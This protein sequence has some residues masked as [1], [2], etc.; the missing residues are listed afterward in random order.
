MLGENIRTCNSRE[1]FLLS[2]AEF[3]SRAQKYVCSRGTY[4]TIFPFL[5]P[6]IKMHFAF[7]ISR[8]A[9]LQLDF[10]LEHLTE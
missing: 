1:K 7:E 8:V 2:G 6:Q 5:K 3:D 9:M 10:L 4:N